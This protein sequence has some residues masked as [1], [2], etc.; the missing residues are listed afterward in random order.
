MRLNYFKYAYYFHYIRNWINIENLSPLILQMELF[1]LIEK[2]IGLK[3]E[4]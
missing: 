3:M 4:K 1:N 2:L